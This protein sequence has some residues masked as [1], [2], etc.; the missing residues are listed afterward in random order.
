VADDT[1]HALGDPAEGRLAAAL[2]YRATPGTC[3]AP[4]A[5]MRLRAQPP[6]GEGG[7]LN[8]PPWRTN[9]FLRR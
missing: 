5:G 3:P 2:A 9:R 8:P 1:G 7:E 4:P 6:P